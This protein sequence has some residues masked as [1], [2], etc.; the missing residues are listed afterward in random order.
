MG[1]KPEETEEETEEIHDYKEEILLLR[2]DGQGR[3]KKFHSWVKDSTSYGSDKMLIGCF[4]EDLKGD[5]D[6]QSFLN[7]SATGASWELRRDKCEPV[8]FIR[9]A[10]WMD[11]VGSWDRPG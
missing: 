1:I 8:I 11:R 3:F 9:G 2:K 5:E 6:M 10:G 7:S 4:T